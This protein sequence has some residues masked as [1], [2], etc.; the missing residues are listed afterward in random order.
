MTFVN[1]ISPEIKTISSSFMEIMYIFH[2]F[3]RLITFEP[4]IFEA[5]KGKNL[6]PSG[7]NHVTHQFRVEYKATWDSKIEC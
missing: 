2:I 1:T 7:V 4:R 3:Y 5:W 6:C